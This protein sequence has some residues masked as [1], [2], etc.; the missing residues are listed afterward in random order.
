[1]LV[2]YLENRGIFLPVFFKLQ[3]GKKL[4][5]QTDEENIFFIQW[6]AR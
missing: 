2:E 5:K 6:L 3:F 1:M 4:Q